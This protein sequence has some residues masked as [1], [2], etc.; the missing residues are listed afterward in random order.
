MDN[1]NWQAFR[2]SEDW[3]CLRDLRDLL[4]RREAK[5]EAK[6]ETKRILRMRQAMGRAR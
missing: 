6:R 4:V 5:R 2:S 1:S 3:L